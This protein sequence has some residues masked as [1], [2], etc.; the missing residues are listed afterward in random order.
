MSAVEVPARCV[1]VDV[2]DARDV[3]DSDEAVVLRL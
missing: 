1:R 3:P 2:E